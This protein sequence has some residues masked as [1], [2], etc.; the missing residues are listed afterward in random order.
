MK[1]CVSGWQGT[2]I[3]KKCRAS[4][5]RHSGPGGRPT[6]KYA[7]G[8]TIGGGGVGGRRTGP[9]IYIYVYS[10]VFGEWFPSNPKAT[11]FWPRVSGGFCPLFL[12]RVPFKMELPR[13]WV[14]KMDP[15]SGSGSINQ[16][17]GTAR[18][19]TVPARARRGRCRTRTGHASRGRRDD[20][21]ADFWHPV[22]HVFDP[23]CLVGGGFTG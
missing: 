14:K 10:Y 17:Q 16:P 5:K 12:E 18:R 13:V 23:F 3:P 8:D 6:Q 1:K 15:T 19:D 22:V 20:A 4:P 2:D 11:F 9:Y 7:E 21:R